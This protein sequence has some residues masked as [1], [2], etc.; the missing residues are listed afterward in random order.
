MNQC[1][2]G[3]EM[4]SFWKWRRAPYKLHPE[5]IESLKQLTTCARSQ[6]LLLRALCNFAQMSARTI[7]KKEGMYSGDG[8]SVHG[9]IHIGNLENA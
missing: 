4:N 8:F 9:Q 6:N 3:E 5:V 2:R 1:A 7:Q